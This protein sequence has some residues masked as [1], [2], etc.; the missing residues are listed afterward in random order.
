MMLLNCVFSTAAAELQT[1]RPTESPQEVREGNIWIYVTGTLF[2][3]ILSLISFFFNLY[4]M[5]LYVSFYSKIL[6]SPFFYFSLCLIIFNSFL[7]LIRLFII[8][9]A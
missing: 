5:D 4:A 1:Q 3:L 7:L 2:S 8:F 9:Y 6:Y